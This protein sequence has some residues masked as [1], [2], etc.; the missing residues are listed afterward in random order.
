MRLFNGLDGGPHSMYWAWTINIQHSH[1]HTPAHTHRYTETQK[2]QIRSFIQASNEISNE[3]TNVELL[4][5][6]EA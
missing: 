2:T 1:A 5:S 4:S 6:V 3:L